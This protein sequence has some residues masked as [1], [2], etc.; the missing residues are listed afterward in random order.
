M[1]SEQADPDRDFELFDD[2]EPPEVELD[3]EPH[4]QPSWLQ[5]GWVVAAFVVLVVAGLTIGIVVFNAAAPKPARGAPT[6]TAATHQFLAALNAGDSSG[7]ANISCAEFADSAR[8]AA[9][10]GSRPDV[11]YALVTVTARGNDH[12]TAEFA[13]HRKIRG[14]FH[15]V[16]YRVSLRRGDKRWL[17]CGQA[18]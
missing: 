1:S 3:R 15:N 14:V 7:A 5:L 11:S 13:Q 16:P 6:P 12:A 4:K 10:S 18:R 2:E 9:R 8:A 17:V